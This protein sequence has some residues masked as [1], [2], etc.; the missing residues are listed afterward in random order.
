M[1]GEWSVAATDC[2]KYLNGRGIG[3][4]YD[5]S[6]G[7]ES[8]HIGDCSAMTGS[9]DN[10]TDEYKEFL[11]KFWDVQTQTSEQYGIGWFFWTW[12]NEE[13]AEWSYKRGMELGFILN[14]ADQHEFKLEDVC[15]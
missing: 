14:K 8:E 3:S 13:A 12:K 2:A 4:R 5:G 1:T 15:K 11:G 10:F 7:G 6:Y 9:G